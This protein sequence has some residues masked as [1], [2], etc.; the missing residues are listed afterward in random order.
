LKKKKKSRKNESETNKRREEENG[1]EREG[2]RSRA[3]DSR[4]RNHRKRRLQ[5]FVLCALSSCCYLLV[6][7]PLRQRGQFP[8]S[9]SISFIIRNFNYFVS[10][11]RISVPFIVCLCCCR[12]FLKSSVAGPQKNLCQ[13]GKN[14]LESFIGYGL[15]ASFHDSF[16]V[17]Y[18]SNKYKRMY[19]LLNF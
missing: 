19:Y 5:I 2:E 6:P 12:H 16:R 17:A 11:F 13:D 3:S 9:L 18:A 4:C 10:L 15:A 14:F 1:D 7:S 8:L